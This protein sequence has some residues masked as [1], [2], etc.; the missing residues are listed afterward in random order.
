MPLHL[1]AKLHIPK[2]KA[3]ITFRVQESFSSD[4]DAAAGA[5][6]TAAASA[7]AFVFITIFMVVAM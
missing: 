1:G 5:A 6:A 3:F 4:T 2:T 7:A